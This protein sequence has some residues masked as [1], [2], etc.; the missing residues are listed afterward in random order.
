MEKTIKIGKKSVRLNNN[1]GWAME[2]KSQFGQDIIPVLMPLLAG[3]LDIITGILNATGKTEEIDG[4]DI[5]RTVDGDTLIDAMAHL[6]ALEFVDFINITWA[7]AKCADDEIPE[8]KEWVKEFD[9]FPVDTIAPAVFDLIA[10]GVISSKNLKRLNEQ[11]KRIQ[12]LTSTPSSSQE[13]KEG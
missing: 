6:S 4:I 5:L 13:Q 8:P 11:K 3:S 2:Y 7:L 1:I 9:T 10:K 12:P